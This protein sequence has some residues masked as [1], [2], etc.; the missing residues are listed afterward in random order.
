LAILAVKRRES[1]RSKHREFEILTADKNLE[2]HASGG[3]KSS[4]P[5]TDPEFAVSR[6]ASPDLKKLMKFADVRE[7]QDMA[8][9]LPL[10]SDDSARTESTALFLCDDPEKRWCV[11]HTKSRRE[12]KVAEQSVRFGIRHYFPLRKSITGRRGRRYTSMVPIF[13]GY[14]FAYIDWADRRRLFQTGHIASVI[15]VMD[16]D[17][18]VEELKNIRLIEE[19]GHFLHPVLEIAKGKRVRIIDGP[20]SGLDGTVIRIKGKSCIVLAVDIIRQAVACEID[21]GMLVLA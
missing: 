3:Y 19:T 14:V 15:D 21:A 12:K 9:R 11:L 18:L 16:Q 17:N 4:W 20:L 8:E 2:E 10:I 13:S 5:K 1:A 7:N 6:T